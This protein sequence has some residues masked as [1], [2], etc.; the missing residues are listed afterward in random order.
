MI[1]FVYAFFVLFF[2]QANEYLPTIE[3]IDQ[4]RFS[5]NS[6]AVSMPNESIHTLQEAAMSIQG[7]TLIFNDDIKN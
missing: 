6:G 4:T 3:V 7:Q 1:S 5:P 2:I